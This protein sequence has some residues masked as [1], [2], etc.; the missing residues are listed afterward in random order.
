MPTRNLP[1]AGCARA[2]R[3]VASTPASEAR[4]KWRRSMPRWRAT[5]KR[6]PIMSASTSQCSADRFQQFAYADR[7]AL[8]A[9]EARGHDLL[10]LL[11]HDR[12]RDSDDR[13][14]AS[15]GVSSNP[16]K[17]LHASDPG[18]LDIHQ[19]KRWLLLARQL[20]ALFASPGLD[21]PVALDLERVAHELQVFGIVLND[22]DQLIRHSVPVSRT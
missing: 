17:G 8:E 7:F 1:P 3:G 16:A 11:G 4:R 5:W 13:D 9:V 21:R 10:A 6:W 20:Y 2:W 14:R 12:R 18:Q 15:G 19:D 22:E